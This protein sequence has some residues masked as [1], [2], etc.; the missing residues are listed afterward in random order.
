MQVDVQDDKLEYIRSMAPATATGTSLHYGILLAQTVAM[1]G[2][3]IE[4]AKQ[5][6]AAIE[7]EEQQRITSCA[8][9]NMGLEKVYTIVHKLTCIAWQ[10]STEQAGVDGGGGVLTPALMSLLA[11]LKREAEQACLGGLGC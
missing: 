8:Q 5:V 9:Q 3:I 4:R 6:A 1:P 2:Q 11:G 10:A 7:A